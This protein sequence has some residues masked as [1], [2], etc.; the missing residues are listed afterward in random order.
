MSVDRSTGAEAGRNGRLYEAMP[1]RWTATSVAVL[2]EILTSRRSFAW[3]AFRC[4]L[5]LTFLLMTMNISGKAGASQ[6]SVANPGKLLSCLPVFRNIPG[7]MLLL[8]GIIVIVD[9]GHGARIE[10]PRFLQIDFFH[11]R[12]EGP[13]VFIGQIGFA[14]ILLRKDQARIGKGAHLSTRLGCAR[15]RCIKE[16][17]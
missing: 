7:Q 16:L 10:A 2:F 3:N 9:N 1:A 6:L 13:I 17:N 8:K 11:I 15:L 14:I 12:L 4:S 5:R